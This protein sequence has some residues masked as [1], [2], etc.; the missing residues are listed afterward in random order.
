MSKHAAHDAQ[1]SPSELDQFFHFLQCQL[2]MEARHCMQ[3]ELELQDQQ[4]RA[5]WPHFEEWVQP[6]LGKKEKWMPF[7]TVLGAHELFI[8]ENIHHNPEL[9]WDDKCKFLAMFVFRAHCRGTIFREAQLPY[10]RGQDFWRDPVSYFKENGKITQS[11]LSYRKKTGHP[12]QTSAFLAIPERLCQDDDENL[13]KNVAQRTRTLL[14]VA[15]QLWPILHNSSLASVEKFEEISRTIQAAYRLGETWA[16]MLMV[17]IDIA[18][19]KEQLLANSCDVGVGALKALQRLFNG[20]CALDLRDALRRATRAANESQRRAAKG[21]WL[22]LGQ[23]EAMAKKRFAKLPLVLRQVNTGHGQVS[24]VTMQVQLCEWRQFMDH[25]TK[26]GASV[27]TSAGLM[28]DDEEGQLEPAQKYRRVT[29]KRR[30]GK[31]DNGLPEAGSDSE[32]DKPLLYLG[33]AQ[34][35]APKTAVAVKAEPARSPLPPLEGHEAAFIQQKRDLLREMKGKKDRAKKLLQAAEKALK[36]ADSTHQSLKVQVRD[37]MSQRCTC[38]EA[39]N[40]AELQVSE[41]SDLLQQSQ[42]DWDSLEET[43]NQLDARFANLATDSNSEECAS[44]PALA[45]RLSMASSARQLQMATFRDVVQDEWEALQD[46]H[47]KLQEKHLDLTRKSDMAMTK[48]RDAKE[49]VSCKMKALNTAKQ[50]CIEARRA[51]VRRR[52]EWM[53][54]ETQVVALQELV[55]D[56]LSSA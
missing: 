6:N 37:A 27:L 20:K 9:R 28:Y 8:V 14:E 33:K 32:D 41:H 56:S 4:A 42:L 30:Q 21:F 26:A 13:A 43:F 7:H 38:Q 48:L 3:E 22:L 24:A 53:T 1:V 40:Q 54:I 5:I 55:I 17:S 31:A 45:E 46:K 39:L 29:G 16:K 25:L 18:Y 51:V 12:L 34:P 44:M 35:E 36:S 15:E 10:M 50:T 19:P 49:E 11:M 52:V 23:V 47:E 2:R